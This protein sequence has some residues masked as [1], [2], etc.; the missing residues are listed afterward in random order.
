AVAAEIGMI[1]ELQERLT[2]GASSFEDLA[3]TEA[4][5]DAAMAKGLITAEE[6]DDALASLNKEQARLDRE[7]EKAGRTMEA[8][9]GRYD[10]A[11]AALKRLERDEDRL[12]KAVDSGRISREQYNRAMA[13]I[14]AERTRLLAVRDGANQSAVAM[15]KLNLQSM[16]TQRNLSQLVTYGVMGRWSMAGS[17]VMQ[18]GNQAGIAGMLFSRAGLAI[19]GVTAGLGALAAMAL[20]NYLRMRALESALIATGTAAGTSADHLMRVRDVVGATTGDYAAAQQ[21]VVLLTRSTQIG[22]EVMQDAASA[23]VNLSRLTGDSIEQTT[24]KIIGLAKAPTAG[25]LEIGRAH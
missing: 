3:D 22:A 8:T 9:I 17:Q 6:Y 4:R 25:L 10:K 12:R 15:R 2:R 13:G 21:A 24:Q 16:E 23:A 19:G 18:L 14:G 5:L 7:A 1:G 20:T 11:G